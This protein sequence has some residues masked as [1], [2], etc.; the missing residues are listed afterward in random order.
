MVVAIE[1]FPS[2]VL[3]FLFHTFVLFHYLSLSL[4][5][6]IFVV[7]VFNRKIDEIDVVSCLMSNELL[8]VTV[9]ATTNANVIQTLERNCVS[10]RYEH[11]HSFIKIS[12]T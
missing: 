2:L 11:I 5:L 9:N 8:P 6:C 1:N 7:G 10:E 3:L 12:H 4:S